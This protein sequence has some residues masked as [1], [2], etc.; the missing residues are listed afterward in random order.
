MAK[1]VAAVYIYIYIYISTN[2]TNRTNNDK[3]CI[4]CNPYKTYKTNNLPVWEW[5]RVRYMEYLITNH[6][7]DG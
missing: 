5:E 2:L 3:G 4:I 7:R 1:T 6:I